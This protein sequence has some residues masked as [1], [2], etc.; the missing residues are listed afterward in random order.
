MA[1]VDGIRMGQ[2]M[3][4]MRNFGLRLGYYPAEDAELA[5][6]CDS[7]MDTWS[8]LIDHIGAAS[9]AEEDEKEELMKNAIVALTTLLTLAAGKRKANEWKYTAGDEPTCSDFCL[10][11]TYFDFAKNEEC[12]LK[13][14]FGPVF[15]MF[16]EICEMIESL[17]NEKLTH[18]L[19]NRA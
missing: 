10:A 7:L 13:P 12:P 15:E 4:I 9:Q 18:H 2:T 19:E 3:A 14:V 11:A 1:I 8:A 6:N 17:K 5:W 16:P